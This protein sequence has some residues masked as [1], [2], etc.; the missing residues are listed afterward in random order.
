MDLPK[1][2]VYINEITKENLVMCADFDN[3]D[4]FID[5]CDYLFNDERVDK[6]IYQDFNRHYEIT[7][8]EILEKEEDYEM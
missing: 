6:I 5:E 4:K 7:K 2:E 8:E 1:G 3:Y